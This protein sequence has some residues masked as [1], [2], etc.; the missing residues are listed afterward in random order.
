MAGALAAR[1]LAR[2]SF[3]TAFAA[4]AFARAMLD[5]EA[6][7]AQAQAEEGVI[8]EA[9]ARAIVAA[10]KAVNVDEER[11]VAEGKRSATLAVPLVDQLRAE[12]SRLSSDAA[13]HVHFG[14]TSQDVL[15][16]AMALCLKSC[17][18]E[19]D[20]SL[21]GAVR[22]LAAKAREHAA[23]PMMGRTL[24]QPALPITAGLSSRAGRSR[25]RTIAIASPTPRPA[26]S[27]CN[28]AGRWARWSRWERKARP[29][30]IASPCASR[31]PMHRR[32]TCIATRGWTC[33]T[34]S[35]RS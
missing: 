2:P 22:S 35:A 33:S 20:R 10:C 24:M 4:P 7:L 27:R 29:C 18:D 12:V 11:L 19:A 34:A 3:E 14:A 28:W 16:T 8:P 25:S 31:S 1:T 26:G 9:A 13:H 6:A 23:T 30:A 32:G 17:L 15:D 21:E 5:F